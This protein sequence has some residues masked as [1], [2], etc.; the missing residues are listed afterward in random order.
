LP[1]VEFTD[2]GFYIPKADCY[3][4][5]DKKVD[6]A[7]ITHG[8]SDHARRGHGH[9]R[10]TPLTAL[11]MKHRYQIHTCE[12]YEF[13]TQFEING[14]IFS[15][16]PAG[17]VPGSAQVRIEC[18]GE[19][20][21]IT[22]DYKRDVDRICAPFELIPCDHFVTE[23]TFGVPIYRWKSEEEL[24]EEIREWWSENQKRGR[25]SLLMGYS[26]GKA[27]RLMQMIEEPI[28]PIYTHPVVDDMNRVLMEGGVYLHPAQVIEGPNDFNDLG[29]SLIIA[30]PSAVRSD[31]VKS[32]GP[33]SSASASG[34]N[35]SRRRRRGHT[36]ENFVISD[37]ADWP[38]LIQT[39]EQTG[40]AHI[41]VMHGFTQIFGS[42]LR[43]LG[44]DARTVHHR[45]NQRNEN[46]EVG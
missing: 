11:I 2:R 8:H 17:H 22:G 36:D 26:L 39:V 38:Q 35:Q 44:Y 25:A 29:K 4:D 32:I 18:E 19:V 27:Q 42:H 3:V 46:L 31:W 9:Y 45:L 33:F 40:A 12:T 20:W 34:W 7:I 23:C 10:A 24:T 30:P 28:G 15:F 13:G 16:H 1:L 21:V 14:V 37:H 43:D 6:N 41:Y 5:P